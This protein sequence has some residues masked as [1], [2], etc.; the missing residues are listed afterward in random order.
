MDRVKGVKG[1]KDL[2]QIFVISSDTK[3]GTFTDEPA[4]NKILRANADL[5]LT[6][7]FNDGT[8]N[9]VVAILAGDDYGLS[10]KVDTVTT[11]AEAL[12]A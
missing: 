2:V 8:A 9:F 11:T 6:V 12:L 3:K 4:T 1:N 10:E 5:T 7:K